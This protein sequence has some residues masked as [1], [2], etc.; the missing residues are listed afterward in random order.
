MGLRVIANRRIELT[1]DEWKYYQDICSH[2]T[3]GKELFNNLFETNEEGIITFL[4]PP[5]G[6]FSM[7]VVLFLQNI[8]VHQ[9]IRKMHREHQQVLNELKQKVEKLCSP[10]EPKKKKSLK[11]NG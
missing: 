7:E 3:S 8:M 10:V 2:Y 11:K 5:S 4:R 6:R 9:Y 1:E